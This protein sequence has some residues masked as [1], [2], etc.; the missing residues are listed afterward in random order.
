MSTAVGVMEN[1]EYHYIANSSKSTAIKQ[2]KH[3]IP[4]AT[5]KKHPPLQE[6]TNSRSSQRYSLSPSKKEQHQQILLPPQEDSVNLKKRG[7]SS[8]SPS[9]SH[10]RRKVASGGTTTPP[11]L[12]FNHLSP[13]RPKSRLEIFKDVGASAGGGSGGAVRSIRSAGDAEMDISRDVGDDQLREVSADAGNHSNDGNVEKSKK[14][15]KFTAISTSEEETQKPK[16]EPGQ[17]TKIHYFGNTQAEIQSAYQMW[18]MEQ[19]LKEA[20][21]TIEFLEL[22]RK[23][24]LLEQEEDSREENSM[25]VSVP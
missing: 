3:A 24:A 17:S 22:E 11:T 14:S 13:I 10:T 5:N 25:L 7:V 16:Q 2:D 19:L 1:L 15:K 6:K 18:K 20:N 4:T 9:A 23:F 12:D 21:E 8:P